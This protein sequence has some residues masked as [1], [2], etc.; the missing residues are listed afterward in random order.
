MLL[1][2]VDE[3]DPATALR[4]RRRSSR[5][6]PTS[7]TSPGCARRRGASASR[8]AFDPPHRA[9][10]LGTISSVTVRHH[11][12][13]AVAGAAAASAG[14]PRGWAGSPARSTRAAA[15]LRG[16]ARTRAARTSSSA[17]AR[18]RRCTCPASPAST[19]E[20]A[21]GR[22]LSP[23]PRHRR[24]ARPRTRRATA[25]EREW[26][27]LGASRGEAGIL[28]EGIRQ[29]LLRDPT[30]RPALA[31]GD[32]AAPMRQ[33]IGDV[34]LGRQPVPADRRLR[35]PVGLRDVPRSSRRAATSSG[36]ACRAW[37][38]R[39]VFGAMLDRDAGG[40]RLGARRPRG[41]RRPPLPARARWSSRRRGARGPAGS[42]SA[43]SCSIGPW[44]HEARALAAPTAARPTDYD[45][46]HVLLRTLRCVNGLGRDAPG[47]RAGARLRRAAGRAGIRPAP[48][49]N[50]ASRD[51]EGSDVELAPH[52]R[53]AP[54]LRGRRAP[55]RGTTMRDGDTAFVALSWSNAR[56]PQ[57][58]RRGLRA[59]SC[60]PPTTGTSGSRT[61][62]SPT[63]R[64][65]PTCSA[66]R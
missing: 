27:V 26:T 21:S 34:P 64:G 2:S 22:A 50:A 46:D 30:Y 13:S 20:T 40:F 1:D 9:P 5:S 10:E 16:H 6:G 36:C 24:A 47:L 4:A 59:R 14:W 8:R 15:T 49:T 12:D 45:A 3:P 18:P 17:R 31:R 60:A 39:R 32:G 38:G 48:A 58:L 61:A 57:D 55:A 42:S 54:R 43:T 52:H 65:A 41:P 33:I 56:R 63:T 62:S 37:T 11:P 29:A 44:H 28:G 66:A 19:I 53:P 23:G 51:A 7:S 25:R 35:V